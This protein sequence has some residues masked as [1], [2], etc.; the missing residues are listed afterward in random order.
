[1]TEHERPW[2]TALRHA[3]LILA[4]IF[5]VAPF[6]WIALMSFKT[7]IAILSGAISFKPV[8]SN[9][10]VLLFSSTSDYARNF[11]NSVVVS[12]SATF[13]VVL[14]GSAAAYSI[15]RMKLAR[16]VGA[17]V[18][19]WALV[20]HLVPPIILAG[21]WFVFFREFGLLNT[22]AAVIMAHVCLNLPIAIWL[23]CAFIGELPI[24]IEEAAR[25]DGA[26]FP[27]IF[28][29]LV[30][31]LVAPGLVATSLLVF[32]FSWNEFPIALN[33]TS[34]ET[35]TLPV[36][37]AKFAEMLQIRYG[38][39]AAGAMLSLVPAL[40][41]LVVGQRLIVRGLTAGAVK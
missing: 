34:S 5:I 14:T 13:I 3:V 18:L 2:Q 28:L 30:V 23:M 16:W 41:A 38:E 27:M 26:P 1:M 35:A 6:I 4:A 7:Q 21:A 40:L 36:A 25:V 19:L 39:I 9:Y 17:A 24:E 12:T 11:L 32:I 31:P 8:L 29:Q 10:E 22:Y 20:V 33:L 37:I 15:V